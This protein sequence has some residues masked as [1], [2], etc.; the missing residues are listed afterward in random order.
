MFESETKKKVPSGDQVPLSLSGK[1]G[2]EIFSYPL[3]TSSINVHWKVIPPI[4]I[5]KFRGQN[6]ENYRDYG[7]DA[8]SEPSSVVVCLVKNGAEE[9]YAMNFSV[10]VVQCSSASVTIQFNPP[11]SF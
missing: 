11:L 10:D 7:L 6:K 3:S 5:K 4:E 2:K 1:T 8:N 9:S